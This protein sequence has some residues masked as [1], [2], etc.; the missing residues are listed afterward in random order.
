MSAG[1]VLSFQQSALDGRTA[2]GEPQRE[3]GGDG[4]DD[5]G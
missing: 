3:G 5:P 2:V 1:K 4:G